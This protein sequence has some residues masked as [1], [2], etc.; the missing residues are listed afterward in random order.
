MLLVDDMNQL[1]REPVFAAKRGGSLAVGRRY[2]VRL[3]LYR[4]SAHRG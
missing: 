2:A 3:V 1:L 4:Q